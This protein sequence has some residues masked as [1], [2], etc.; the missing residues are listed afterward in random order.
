ML[1][2]SLLLIAGILVHPST[3]AQVIQRDI[4]DFS[5][6]LGTTPSRSMAAGLVQPSTGTSFHGGLDLTHDSGLY[7][8]QWSPSMGLSPTSELEVDSYM[9]YKHPF[10]NTLGYEVGV[11]QY[12]YPDLDVADTHAFYAGL[13]ILDRRFGVAFNNTPDVQNSTLFADLG[14][15]PLLNVGFTMKVSNHQLTTP[16]TIGEG[17]EVRGFNDWSLQMS[18]PLGGFDLNFSYSGSDLSGANCAAYS[19]QNGQCDSMF[20]VKAEH[21]FF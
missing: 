13:R 7:F 19:G 11:I 17:Q 10:D 1:R 16:F 9:G 20:M 21:T 5:L 15:L 8:G 12:S 3:Y 14:G 6:K 2:P 4:G 18:R